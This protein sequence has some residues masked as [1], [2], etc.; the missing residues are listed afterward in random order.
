[1]L[2]KY[3]LASVSYG[4][5]IPLLADHLEET[6]E[7]AIAEA[8]EFLP[9]LIAGLI[10]LGIGYVIANRLGP[11]AARLVE[12]LQVDS[13]V[14]DSQV[15][16]LL[17]GQPPAQQ[18]QSQ[19][20]AQ[21]QEG[22]PPQAP[23]RQPQLRPLSRATGVVVKYYILLFAFYLAVVRMGLEETS[24]WM[25]RL[26]EYAPQF[27]A[28]VAIIILGIIFADYA[29]AHARNSELATESPYGHWITGFVGAL[30][31]VVVFI[32]GLE[33]IGFDLQIVYIIV[34]G[35]ASGIGVGLTVAIALAVGVAAALFAR[36]YYEENY[37]DE[38]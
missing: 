5:N 13:Q 16:D 21:Q 4:G 7:G 30:L 34:D 17:E 29:I 6:V 1:M 15:G 26:L 27:L 22:Q 24:L 33:M 9:E 32:I 3:M 20:P 8:I 11:F 31:Y 2:T 25:E 37:S 23:P 35:V 12:R 36:D 28:G 14:Q 10:I 19:P 38:S 18:P